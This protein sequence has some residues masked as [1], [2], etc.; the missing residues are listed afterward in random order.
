MLNGVNFS[1]LQIMKP[2]CFKWHFSLP[3]CVG[4]IAYKV[5]QKHHYFRSIS[6]SAKII[7]LL[8][9]R[10]KPRRSSP[11]WRA[12][13]DASASKL[14]PPIYPAPIPWLLKEQISK[15]ISS[16][17]VSNVTT[18]VRLV[19]AFPARSRWAH[20]VSYLTSASHSVWSWA[21][22]RCVWIALFSGHPLPHLLPLS[23]R[24]Q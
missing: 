19:Q 24:S 7:S 14:I 10:L 17:V 21:S 11:H 2:D 1:F 18:E 8:W 13:E 6:F 12:N 9:R 20:C 3:E 4:L 23:S 15:K 5:T 16:D 22:Q